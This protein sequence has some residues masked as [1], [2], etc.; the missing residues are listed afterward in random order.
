MGNK[1]LNWDGL[2]S[3]FGPIFLLS[4]MKVAGVMLK[5]VG[6]TSWFPA[7]SDSSLVALCGIQLCCT[8]SVLDT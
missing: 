8:A 3:F 2:G 7:L 5:V 1:A 4:P 6:E